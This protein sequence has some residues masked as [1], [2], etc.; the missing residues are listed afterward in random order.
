MDPSYPEL[1]SVLLSDVTI[2]LLIMQSLYHISDFFP[3]SLSSD[4]FKDSRALFRENLTHLLPATYSLSLRR[5]SINI[6]GFRLFK[7]DSSWVRVRLVET[8]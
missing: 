2:S 8:G 3:Y 5:F 7:A 1:P 6:F 4:S